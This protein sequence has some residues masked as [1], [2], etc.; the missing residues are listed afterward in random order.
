MKRS[1]TYR[2]L[3][4]AAITITAGFMLAPSIAEWT[5]RP[6]PG[7]FKNT[8]WRKI[9]LGVDLKG[10]NQL[11]IEVNLDKPTLDT[12]DLA[13]GDLKDLFTKENVS[14]ALIQRF[15]E[16][17]ADARLQ[18]TLPAQFDSKKVDKFL[19]GLHIIPSETKGS[20]HSYKV[21]P[22][23]LN[24]LERHVIDQSIE[25]VRD[26]VDKFGVR[27]AS[28]RRGG[29]NKI[30]VELPGVDNS[31]IDRLRQVIGR[32]AQLEFKIVDQTSEYTFGLARY[33]E[34]KKDEWKDISV[35]PESASTYSLSSKDVGMLKQFLASLPNE[36]KPPADHEI[37]IGKD[38]GQSEQDVVWRT[39]YVF[40]KAELTGQYLRDA[41]VTWA[42]P[43]EDAGAAVK[44]NERP[45]V[46]IEFNREGARR[47]EKL[48]GENINKRMAIILEGEVNSAPNIQTKISGGRATITLGASNESIRVLL[49]R[50]TELKTVLRTGA[51]PAPL[52][53]GAGSKIGPTLGSEVVQKARLAMIVGSLAVILFMLVYYKTAGLIAN[54]AM[55]LNL[56]YL[57]AIMAMFESTLTLPGIAA[58][59]LTVGMAVDA[60]II[61]YERIREEL[62]SGKLP[63][64]AVETGFKRAFWTVF[65]AHVTNLVAGIVLYS[66][67]SGAIRGF[68]VSLIAGIVCNLFTSVWL[69][70]VFFEW[71][72]SRKKTTRLSI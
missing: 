17:Q 11:L 2:V 28:V 24:E 66:Y 22:D 19:R 49:A 60:N 33:W 26:R 42:S 54:I 59:V 53:I 57:L 68:A 16:R 45:V 70:R 40:R 36:Q 4:Y 67:G 9:S 58:V 51:L 5:N 32:T 50:A 56:L 20:V 43:N 13:A 31:G 12:L 46:A 30:L 52:T 55:V 21:D 7:W 63:R 64:S 14:N 37:L 72:V 38:V 62:R 6:L 27:E 41:D 65:D 44:G 18:V 23:Y 61:I 25:K 39:Y 3:L 29:S 10:G 1:W 48:T 35:V 47:F 69:S 8:F 71:M 34:S 15:G